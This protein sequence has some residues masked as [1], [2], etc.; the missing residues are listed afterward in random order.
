MRRKILASL[1]SSATAVDL[2]AAA[3]R[4]REELGAPRP[5]IERPEIDRVL[6]GARRALVPSAFD[7]AW[8]RGQALPINEAVELAAASLMRLV[9]TSTR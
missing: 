4:R 3:T 5:D 1:E 6:Q 9:E 2:L 7:A 8:N